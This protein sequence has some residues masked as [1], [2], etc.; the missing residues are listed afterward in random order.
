[1]K[2]GIERNGKH[3]LFSDVPDWANDMTLYEPGGETQF[4]S[5]QPY[6]DGRSAAR[7]AD[8]SVALLSAILFVTKGGLQAVFELY[9]RA[10]PL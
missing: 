5:C 3:Y 6:T 10:S 8:S 2:I 7:A 1:M 9:F 4:F